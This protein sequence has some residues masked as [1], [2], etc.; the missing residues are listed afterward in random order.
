M[1][2]REEMQTGLWVK[3]TAAVA[4]VVVWGTGGSERENSLEL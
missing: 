2:K 1:R 3:L 4:A